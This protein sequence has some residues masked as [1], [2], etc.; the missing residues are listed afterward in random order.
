MISSKLFGVA[1]I[2]FGLITF[3]FDIFDTPI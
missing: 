3:A 2:S 1:N